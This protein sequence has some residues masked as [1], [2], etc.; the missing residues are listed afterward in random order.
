M[1]KQET[2]I[3][4]RIMV[5]C[6]DIAILWRANV[7]KFYTKDLRIVNTGLPKG[8][9]DLFGFRLKDQKIIFIEVKTSTGK[10]RQEQEHFLEAMKKNGC[11]CGV[12]RNTL[13]AREI[14]EQA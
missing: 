10:T 14:I 9:S 13:Q 8:F 6:S 7:G 5:E 11:I 4:R 12:A 1:I 3:M 2:E